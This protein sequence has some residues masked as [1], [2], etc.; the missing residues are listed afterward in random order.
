MLPGTIVMDVV[1]HV[2]GGR[3]LQRSIA[4]TSALAFAAME[5]TGITRTRNG[6]RGDGDKDDGFHGWMV[7]HP[8]R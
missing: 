2:T 8:T 5:V 7:S 6:E 1:D 3:S 4:G